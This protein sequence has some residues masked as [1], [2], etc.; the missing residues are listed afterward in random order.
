LDGFSLEKRSSNGL[1]KRDALP[2]ITEGIKDLFDGL[3]RFWKGQNQF[4]KFKKRAVGDSFRYP[5]GFKLDEGNSRIYLPKLGW[6]RYR[7]SRQIVGTP[8][9]VTVLV[10][11]DGYYISIQTEFQEEAPLPDMSEPI[12]LDLGVKHFAALSNGDFYEPLDLE[13]EE[14]KL[15]KQQ[16]DV[17]RKVEA[18]KK[19]KILPKKGSKRSRKLK[20]EE[21][22]RLKKARKKAH[23][24]A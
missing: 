14:K 22:K 17:F 9:N 18:A 21:S 23:E 2:N 19:N 1:A 6:L 13:K 3:D 24:T 16:L 7:K 12:G 11:A 5:Q 10:E 8:K 4:S 20:R 15:K